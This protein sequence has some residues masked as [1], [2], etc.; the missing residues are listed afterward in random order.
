MRGRLK[1]GNEASTAP[2]PCAPFRLES[3]ARIASS[4]SAKSPRTDGHS[5][6]PLSTDRRAAG[7]DVTARVG[8]IGPHSDQQSS[9]RHRPSTRHGPSTF[10]PSGPIWIGEQREF[11]VRASRQPKPSVEGS[12]RKH[13]F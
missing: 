4:T 10:S 3:G 7:Y 12:G 8:H 11:E 9:S 13:R 5:E 2:P 1:F 6:H